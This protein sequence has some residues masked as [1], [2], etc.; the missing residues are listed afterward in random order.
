[1]SERGPT[2]VVAAAIIKNDKVL[3][4]Q[5]VQPELPEAHLKWELPGGK[6]KLEESPHNALVREIKE[7]LNTDIEIIRLL[8]HVQSNIYHGANQVVHSVVLAF[9]SVIAKGAELPRP[10]ERAVREIKWASRADMTAFEL[11]PGTREFVECLYL[12]DKA[13]YSS[14]N[15]YVRLERRRAQGPVTDY[16]ELRSVYDLWKKV[17][18]IERHGNLVT[19]VSRQKVQN[20][21]EKDLFDRLTQRIRT[22]ASEGYRITDTDNPRFCLGLAAT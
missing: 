9:E 2:L 8:P 13:S 18:I 6:V 10:H 17:N 14:A 19:R 4:A 12:P 16:W 20:V 22:L 21:D 3:L 1:M 7:E 15:I 5:R 11:L